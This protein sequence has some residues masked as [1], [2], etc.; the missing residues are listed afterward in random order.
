M[1]RLLT[2]SS[3]VVAAATVAI[4]WYVWSSFIMMPSVTVSD[5]HQRETLVLG[6]KVGNPYTYG[7]TIRGSGNIDGEA[8]IS[9]MLNGEPYKVAK[10]SSKFDFEWGGD[11]YSETAEVRYEPRNVRSG[12]VTLRYRFL[13][14]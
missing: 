2:S 14:D 6:S 13:S 3:F 10:L 1:K 7:I 5:V 8:I 4:A 9:L 12:R 11:W